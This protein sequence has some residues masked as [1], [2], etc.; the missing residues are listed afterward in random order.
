MA[1]TSQ[2]AKD[3]VKN[4]RLHLVRELRNLSVILENLYQQGVLC[5]EEVSKIQAERDGYDKT[6]KILDSVTKKGEAACYVL[7]KIIDMTRKRTL[8]RPPLLPEKSSDAPTES[9]KFDLHHWISCF[10]FKDTHVDV[11]YLQ[12]PRPC[13]RYQEKLKS[14]VKKISNEFWLTSKTLFGGNKKPDLSYTSLVLD[15]EESV[16]PCKIKKLKKKKSN[17]SRPK[18]L[19]KYIPEEKPDISPTELLETDKNILLVGKPGI[20]KTTLTHEMLRL[21]AERESKELD[22]MFYFDMRET[23]HIRNAKSLEELLFGVFCEPDDGKDEVLQD[24]L[25]H[26]DNVTIIFDGLTDLCSSVVEKL[27]NKD[28]LPL[29]KIIITCRADDEDEDLFS[30]NFDRVEVKGFSEQTIKTYLSATLGED[31]TKVLSNLE[32]VTLCHVPM[33]ALMVA[34]CFSSKDAPQPCTI[35]EIYI[36]IVRF[37]LQINS[38]TK[39]K[40]LNSFI[41]TKREE[42]LSLAEVAFLS[43]ERKTV[44]L[45]DLPCEDSCVLSFLKPLLIKEAVTE[46][47]TT[48][49]FLHYT[50]QEFFAALWLLKNPDKI[51]DVFQQCLK[52]EKKHMKHL[53]PFMC[54]LLNEKSPSLMKHLIPDKDLKNTSNWFFKELI[55]TFHPHLC[56][57]EEADTEDSG[58]HVDILFLCQCLYE[59]QS[60]EACI[61]LLDK[62]DY[63]LDLSGESLD[64]YPCCAVAYVITQSKE[65]KILMNLEDVIISEQGMRQLFGC[66][67]NV[68]WCDPLPR[69][70]WEIF[71]VSEEQMDFVSLLSL[72]GNQLHLPVDGEKHLFERAVEIIQR[73]PT[74]VN[75][76][77][78]WDR[79][80][81]ACQS[82]CESL[83]EALL[84]I[85]SLSFRGPESWSQEKYHGTLEREQK[86]L[87]MDLCLKAALHDGPNFYNVVKMLLPLFPVKT[88]VDNIF[89]DLFQYVKSKEFLG[90]FQGLRPFFQ[91]A[92][93][94][95]SIN[96]SE[97]KTSILL[98][99]LKL[100]PEKKH[101]ELTGCS[102]EESEVRS[103]LQCL[104]YISQ[105]SVVPQLSETLEEIRF[106]VN[107]FCAA[108]E[109]EQQT[110]EKMMELL[111]SMCTYRGFPLREKWC[112]FLMDLYSFKT[113]T[114]LSVLP[115]L[116]SVFQ[117][118]PAVWSIN[119]SERKTSILLEVLKL[120]PEKKQVELTGCSHEESEVR[121]FLQCLPYISQLSVS[122]QS[123][124]TS[125]EIRFFGNLFCAAAER[126][127]Q[128][129]EKMMELLSSVCTYRG[130]HLKEKWCDFLM[131]LYAYDTKTVMSVLP[132]LQS[133]FQS[134]PA[135]WSINL[136]ERKTSILLEVLK[137][138]PEKKQVKLTGCSHEESEVRS[139]LQCLPYI[140]QLSF[141]T[142]TSEPSEETRFFRNLFCAAAEREQQTGE[143]ILEL[144][145]SVCTY[146]TFILRQKWCDFLMDLYSYETKTGL[147]VLPSLQSVFQSA[148]AVWSINL[149]E[150]KT[151]ILLEV[152]KLQPEK[153][154][155][156]LTGCS[157]EESE[158][159]KLL[160]CLPY[161]S[162]L[163]FVTLLSKP[164]EEIRFFGNLFC[165]AAKRQEQTGEKILELLSSVCRYKNF[166]LKE[167]WCDFLIDLYYYRTKT[168]LSV[169]PSLKSVFQSTPP[170]WFIN[171]SE[172]K[173]SILLEVLK[174][175]PEKKQVVLTGC[176]HEESEVRSFL[177]CLPYISQL[178]VV[179]GLSGPS[180]ETRFFVNLFCAAAE[181]EQQTGE[182]ILELLSSVCTY[183]GFTVNEIWC[184]FLLDLY[185]HVKDC[186][187]KTGLSVLPSLQ[188]VFQSAP[189]VW[190]INLS[191][192]KT[193]ILL[194]VLK[195][196][197]EKK[198]VELTGFSHEES[199]V[200]S[201]LQ[202]LPYIS[203]LSFVPL[204]SQ[205]LETIRFIV[206]LFCAAAERE[207]QMGEKTLELLSSVCRYRGFP[208]NEIC[209]DFL[210]DLYSYVKDCET[211]TGLSVLPS[212]QSVFQSAPAVWSINLSERKTSILL[213]VLKL[214]PEKKQV[215]LTGCSHEESEVRSFLQ[216][217]PYISQ[218]SIISQLSEPSEETRF[219]GKLFCAAAER[220]QQTGEKILELLS[221]VCRYRGFPINLK[222]CDF[223]LDL[224][225]HAKDYETKTGLSVL[226]SLQSVFQS[227]PAVWS[228]NLSE[229]K[230]SI[231]L[232]V[233][234]LQPEKKQVEL[235]GCS[236]EESE[237]RSFLQC[238]PYIS[239]LSFSSS[240]LLPSQTKF[241]WK[242]GET[243]KQPG[244]KILELLSSVCRYHT[245]PFNDRSLANDDD[246]GEYQCDFLLDLYSY[247]KDY[248]TKTGLSVLPSLQS[249]FQSAPA[250]WFINL[251]ERKTSILLEVLKLQPEKKQVV[252]TG[253]SHEESEVRSFLQCLPYISQL[254]VG[255]LKSD[256][257]TRLYGKLFC[258]AA[259]REQ[260]TGE[261]ILELL[262]SVCTYRGFPINLKWCDFLLDLFSYLKSYDT[263]TGLSV[264]PSLQS[265]FQSAPAVWF[266]N[267]SER[268]TSILLEVLKL[269][270]EKKQVELT[271][272]SHE[273][274]EVRS[275]LQCLPYISQLSVTPQGSE[276]FR[277]FGNLFCAAAER[278]QQTGE[279]I[280]ELLSSVCRYENFPV[281]GRNMAEEK[282]KEF[283]CEFLLDL[284]SCVK[285]YETK[286]GLSVLP[287]LQSVFQST[288]AVW[289]INLSERKTSILLEVLKLQPEKKQVE[290]TGCSHEEREVGSFLQ[291]LPYISQ[292][293]FSSSFLLPSQTKSMWGGGET[294]KQPGEKILELFS[295]FCKTFPFNYTDKADD[296]YMKFH[297]AFLLDLYSHVKDY[298][299]KTGLSVLP[300]L[301]S[302]FQSAPAVWF[303]N[304]SERKTS[305]LLEVLK[306]QPEKKQVKLT[307]CSH[308]ESEV[309]SFLQ[310]L[311]Y[312][313]QLRVDPQMSDEDT[314]SLFVNL[315]CA[316]AER[317]QQTGEKILELLSSVCRYK[318]FPFEEQ[319][320]DFLMDVYSSGTKMGLSVLPSL[321]SVFQSAPAVWFINLSERKT[322]ILL[323]VLK[324]QPEKKQVE[325]TGCSHEE[326]EVRSFLQCL[327]YISQLSVNP[328]WSDEAVR[329]FGNLFCAAAEREQRTG[330]KILEL[331]SSVCT[332]QTFPFHERVFDDDDHV[333]SQCDFLLDLYS[334]VKDYDT[335]SGLS[336]LPSLQSVF[337]SAPA[338]WSIKLS[339][340]KTSILLEVLK[341]QPEKK[342]VELTGC[343][344]EESE[345]GSFLQCLPYISQL[346]SSAHPQRS[347]KE[348]IRFFVN[349]FCAAAE[350]EHHTGEKTLE[351]LSSVCRNETFKC[352][353]IFL[354]DLYSHVKDCETKTGL[355]VLPSLQ[356][357]FQSAPAVWSIK[358]SERKT[359]I[360]LEVLKLQP[361]KKQVELTG[362]SHEES[363]VRS[364]LQCLP[365]ISQLSVDPDRSR[366][367]EAVR[368][369]VNLFCAAA[370][371]EQQTGEKILELLSSVCT[372][373]TF[374]FDE[375][376]INWY[377]C[378]FLL[379]L[380]SHMKDYETETGL[381]VLPSLQ[382]I[383]QST[384]EV[385][386]IKLSERK[387][388]IL[389]EVLKLQP[390]KKQVELTGCSHEESEVRS[391]LQ[392]LPYIS[393][394]SVDPQRS[395]SVAFFVNLF[396]AAA[397]REKKTGEKILELLSSVC[398]FKEIID[399]IQLQGYNDREKCQHES[400]CNFLL[401]L[402]AHMKDYETKTGLS[403]LP[404]LQ[405]VFQSAPAVWFIN[406]SERKTSILLEV[407]KLQPEK[408]QMELTGCSHEESEVRSFLQCLPYISQLSVDTKT[409]DEAVRFFGNLFCAAAA[410]EQQTGEKILELLSS[411]CTYK[412]FPVHEGYMAH[413]YQ[414]NFL[415]DLYSHVKAYESK[416]GLSVLPSLQS[417]F[418]SAPAVW[419]INLS[420]RKTS[421]LLEVLKLQPEKKQVKLTDCSH[422][423]SEVRSFLQCLPYISQLSVGSQRPCLHE[424]V[425]YFGNL[426]C[427]AAESEEQTGE[428]ILELL[429]SVC[430]YQT[431]P[432]NE[433]YMDDD[434]G[435]I[436]MI[437]HH[438]E[439][440]QCDFLL[441]LYSHVKDCETKT[442]LSVLPSL[443][444][445]FQS[446]PAVWSIKLSER[447]TSILLEVLKLQPEKKQVKLTG[448]S[449]EESEVRSFLQCLPYI[450]QLSVNLCWP[451]AEEARFFVNLFCAAAEREQ[452]TG[453][454]ILELLSSVCTYQTFPFNERYMDDEYQCDF[455]LDLYSH[456]K[457]SETKTGLGVLPSLQSVFQSAPAVWSINLSER[458][459][460]ILL[461]VL[462]LQPEKK[463]V[464]LRDCTHEESEVRSFLQCLPYISKLSIEY[465]PSDEAVR[466]FVNLFCAAAEREQ[467][468]GEKILELLSS[469]CTYQT[470]PFNESYMRVSQCNFLLDLYSCVKNYEAKTGLSVLPSLQS[471]F[472]APAVWFINLAERKTSIFL[473]VLKLQPEKKQVEL[474]GC[475]QKTSKVRSFL[476]CLPYISQL[477]VDSWMPDE[478]EIRYFGNLFCA[479]AERE[480]QTGE[481]ILELLSSVC[482]YQTFPF[483]E[484]YMN[485]DIGQTIII[486]NHNQRDQRESQCDFL[487]DLYSHMKDCEPK[488]GLSVLPS[489]QSVFQ[490]APAVWSINLSERKTSILLEVL[491]LQPEKKQV[492]L[493]GCS[494]EESEVRSFLQ[495][496]PYISQLSCDPDF[497]QSVC[498]SMSVR[499]REEAEQL[500]SLLQLL[501]FQLLLT[502]E[503]HRKSCWSVGRVLKLC[504]SK[505][506][507]I[508]TPSKM[509]ARGAALLF[510]HTT[511]L[512]S[513]R[514]S[515]D[516]S[517]LLFQWVRRGRVVCPLAVEEL[518]LV[519]K[520]ARPSQRV[521][522]RA[523][524][525]LASLL[526]YWT[527]GRL[528]LTETCI[529]AQG[530]ITLLLHD[531][532]LTVKLNEE[533]FQQLQVLL[534]EIQDKDC[535]TV[536]STVASQQ[537]GP[538]FHSTIRP[539]G[540]CVEFECSPRVLRLPPTVQRHPLSGVRLIGNT[541]L[542]IGVSTNGCLSLC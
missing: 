388:S 98:E 307:G 186:E 177:Q 499:S 407:L 114:G 475:S 288:P 211:K 280:L 334:H 276:S 25:R 72:D 62:L 513:L 349:L 247:V 495:C 354:L 295:S 449:H 167:T 314:I 410:R 7:L 283:Q 467:Q 321:Q 108:A 217:L 518:S 286:T 184:D 77:L 346:S 391:F 480:Q 59:S 442:G 153:K 287:S 304:L 44:N 528:D 539:E 371:R 63:H 376:Y 75:V 214:Q 384:P 232:E 129:G 503:L 5:D 9:K 446:A 491:K 527:V 353:I 538:E 328:W 525:S 259:E 429:S 130:F 8:E 45:T 440:Y 454:K 152:L 229:R 502:G 135:V 86:R 244:D 309:R 506:D 476:Q 448:C 30:G 105:L 15:T 337:Q 361:E 245:F 111:S 76:C 258:A 255:I 179:P 115:S 32:L 522:L 243:E 48:H 367:H 238:L 17:M 113:K 325:L 136:S 351:L 416:T 212:L 213:E 534:P 102:H 250:V 193:S 397:E 183:R 18:K 219:F 516:M 209:C 382:S 10:S 360:L 445:V 97:R 13:H 452:Q 298:E 36:N 227:A 268:K 33:Y 409:S 308:E 427:A 396:C 235:T 297:F 285:E 379:D 49:A 170:V 305:I 203:Q 3:Y 189:A 412:K 441:G 338:V 532:P 436:V 180:E 301:Q 329:F 42:I 461:E 320:C 27:L 61:Y 493:T 79:K 515:I 431:F 458:K 173:T 389:L 323:E 269:Q 500:E 424:T 126:E 331:L 133:V 292:L 540:F 218:L 146:Q 477:S 380:Y 225:S 194:E 248:E 505:V 24:I 290:L 202:C 80:T 533:S 355:S 263:K 310:C 289:S 246:N 58:L 474:T 428:K 369:F 210:L 143:K 520:K 208:V 471:V 362:C 56:E 257:E 221:S 100:Q 465:E 340:R 253:C 57:Q 438:S 110:G 16:S 332:Y 261:K 395:G 486:I 517:L 158:V 402:Y 66:L 157:H 74:K 165:A 423:E 406:L 456:V 414:F 254:S 277:Y 373:Q 159:R 419:S 106:F 67:E 260:Q 207:Q 291:C 205:H 54:R 497:F 240:F 81:S 101:V 91:S 462:K 206:N 242:D 181:R 222:W 199:E 523:V 387:T 434:I 39:K 168:G 138:Q 447:K 401:D 118:A 490:S 176:S 29:A 192:R 124:E 347:D 231:L 252:L 234:K 154:H 223:L 487:L 457:N 483:N 230:T 296:G 11:N 317:E 279:K 443:Q 164:S 40:D 53:I 302:V 342:Q 23:S 507:L 300:S 28:L 96:L 149:S 1:S 501:G 156:H 51:R 415:L 508:L 315:F 2:S 85:S 120:Q 68:E 132:S 95:W 377:Q 468:T 88:D 228:I 333:E 435:H 89:L 155:L 489:L 241:M 460:S 488:T 294:E 46:T 526:R 37:F 278:E 541:N 282:E 220:E 131:D 433:R 172:R 455:L 119:L 93:A 473:E 400:Q 150:R 420:E 103:F 90:D 358:L 385:W 134:A 31:Q 378:D 390:E 521:M 299:T 55:N 404:S 14:K 394:L 109:R 470:F 178:S 485:D 350:K 393:Q 386:L 34:A 237:V 343:S 372:Y 345:V 494:H 272:C 224:Y 182:K 484:R 171:L 326:S 266:I 19:R 432:F 426:F 70:M 341:L 421:I 73:M 479:A 112:D 464:K 524:S 425:R 311:P 47:I 514:L 383:F 418:Q 128:T 529:P 201:F 215:E 121:S 267:L 204:S 312:I 368:F 335:K 6:R 200:R 478:E 196:Q 151:S 82:L 99:V 249:V 117:S 270:P 330:E 35:T 191:E 482:T 403:V 161:I 197:P 542:P 271:G 313:S 71:L 107:L 364:F 274:S 537:E 4:A 357:V 251:S 142:Q 413:D 365:Y 92:P 324:L 316:A 339:E 439:Q 169:L 519:P 392:C 450:S 411:V 216:C 375:R 22:Y 78:Y 265:V 84:F 104:P 190:S 370:E 437:N 336:V 472:S 498:T 374:P 160:Q 510:R 306:L 148:P 163:S 21:W 166:P 318:G 141:V 43:A 536:V 496:L 162:Q 381:S 198:Q 38:K 20:G 492:K 122:P 509:S 535:G 185:S 50:V 348:N 481:K 530:L 116:H 60:P 293:S 174:L 453:E 64:P 145:A 469:V 127:Q 422:E 284:Y 352:D 12:G 366:L 69:Q 459:T 195:L 405:S 512:H 175:Q 256:E 275:F 281:V 187:T 531:G 41:K 303:I 87:F 123:L 359:S 417:V 188:S 83:L 94:V 319:W 466:F 226:P 26:S 144:L 233:L 344:H 140:S 65:R 356:S 236:H 139:F 444:S 504:G 399:C 239:Q 52:E 273:E 430:T 262:S 125:D 363:E 398:N 511:Q 327:P 451:N 322:S 147:S 408:K 463:P 137:L 264:L